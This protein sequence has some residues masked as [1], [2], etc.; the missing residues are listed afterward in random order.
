MI[1]IVLV[2]CSIIILCMS[3][4]PA[5]LFAI[6]STKGQVVS[7]ALMLIGA[8]IG[9]SG[10]IL[11]IQSGVIVYYNHEWFLPWGSFRICIDPLSCVF[12][13]PVFIV[14]S[15]G[16]LYSLSYWSQRLHPEN[17]KRLGA[18][19]GLLAG[20]MALVVVAQDAALFI[21][22]WEIMALAAFFASTAE[23]HNQQVRQAGWVYIVATHIGTLC[24][25]AMFALWK[26]STGS[27]ALVNSPFLSRHGCD[28]L[29]VLAVI[30]FG[31]KAGI[32]PFHVWLPGAHANA[33][34]HVSAVMSGVMLKMGVYG[35]IRMTSLLPHV[36]LWWGGSLLV[37]G[38]IT[39]IAGIAIAIG[40]QDIKRMLAYSSIE[41]IGI[42]MLGLGLALTGRYYGRND[43]VMLGLCGSL[44][45]VWNH[46]L[47]KSLLFLNAGAIIHAVHTRDLEQMG[48][49]GKRMP[50]TAFLFLVG[51]IA[52]C[53]LPP[54]N[55]FV[56]EWLMYTGFF[57]YL[58]VDTEKTFST[59]PLGAVA[60]ATIGPMAIACFVKAFGTI[61]LGNC[62]SENASQAHEAD[63]SLIL[64]M[65]VLAAGCLFIGLIPVLSLDLIVSAVNVWTPQNTLVS[66][67]NAA[68]SLQWISYLGSG[69]LMLI[70]FTA[71]VFRKKLFTKKESAL[72]TWDCGYALP[73]S[74]MQ[75]SS[76]SFGDTI[77]KLFRWIVVPSD[78]DPKI[79]GL[80]PR[81]SA[82]K[83]V[84]P[85]VILDRLVVP[86]FKLAGY[87]L[88]MVR[89]FQRGQV[90]L[91]VLYILVTVIVLLIIGR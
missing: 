31:F 28:V 87:Y 89:V 54:L 66:S 74:R 76:S 3:G 46:S 20:G 13:L 41:N 77:V 80:F 91:Y 71:V 58:Q 61:F 82:F 11:S 19:Y 60:L 34:S 85:D 35:I 33:P 12:L 75:Y 42:I 24:L 56:S 7:S 79:S 49:L 72:G 73:T 6:H 8:G 51:A 26:S 64:P 57:N 62:R 32:I 43:I 37:V 15:V 47:F 69:L 55:G 1:S 22:A 9:I 17:G 27:F 84:V 90:H 44:L 81:K 63:G 67:V 36:Q 2:L 18:F 23:D 48:G 45:H 65:V 78:H 88:P 21:I 68:E 29:F 83:S 5:Y 50:K 14:P 16:T 40:Q 4:F 52:I 70:G 30:G 38:A 86:V 25:F 10:V 53:A 39:G 59:V